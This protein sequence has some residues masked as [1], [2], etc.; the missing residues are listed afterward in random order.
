M[1]DM[2]QGGGQGA[3][4]GGGQPPGGAPGG[5]PPQGG[6]PGGQPPGGPQGGGI[7]QALVMVDQT[8]NKIATAVGQNQQIPDDVKAAAQDALNAY[9]KFENAL[10]KAAGG[11]PQGQSDDDGDEGP[12]GPGTTT[13]QQGGRGGAVPMSHQSMRGR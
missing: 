7:A 12:G 1:P 3:P 6:A 13:P 2:P 5:Q 9:R 11:E 8:L 4:Y 10:V